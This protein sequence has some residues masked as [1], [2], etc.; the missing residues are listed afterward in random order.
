MTPDQITL[1][2]LKIHGK[3]GYYPKERENGNHFEIDITAT[4]HFRGAI[5]TDNLGETFDYQVAEKIVRD[6]INGPSEK[7]IETLCAKI[8]DQLFEEFS[9]ISALTVSLRK[10]NPPIETPTAYAEITMQWSR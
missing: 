6:V 7:L 4:G 3:H 2:S 8:G 5:N 9:S 10:M 1:K